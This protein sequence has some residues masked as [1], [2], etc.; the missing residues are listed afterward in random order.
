M[1]ARN[2]AG[3]GPRAH[4]RRVPDRRRAQARVAPWPPGSCS[5]TTAPASPAGRA[6]RAAH[7][8]GRARGGARHG[9]A[10][11]R[12]RSTV[13]GRTDARRARARPG[14]EPRRATPAPR[15]RAQRRCCPTTSRCSRARRRPRASTPAATPAAAPTATA[16]SPARRPARSSAAARSAW[17]RPL[18]RAALD[19]CA[20]A[21][22]RHARLHRLHAHRD[23]PR[24]LRARGAAGRV[25]GGARGRA[26][27]LDRGR[28]VHAPHGARAGRDDARRRRAPEDAS[29]D[30]SRDGPR[31]EAGATAPPTAFTWSRSRY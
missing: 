22:R 20:A 4:R 5:S 9:P 17:P 27:L 16:C 8:A 15:A 21:L 30:C 28:H 24:A 11:S 23:R 13:A 25:G 31:S 14:G 26:G 12:W 1:R 18:D 2:S 7:G 19:A 3:D 29:S 6:S 10:A